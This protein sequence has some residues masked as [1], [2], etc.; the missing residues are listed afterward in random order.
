MINRKE[1]N[2]NLGVSPA[3]KKGQ[4]SG[5]PFQVRPH[6]NPRASG[7]PLLSLTQKKAAGGNGKYGWQGL[8]KSLPAIFS[9]PAKYFIS[10]TGSMALLFYWGFV[11]PLTRKSGLRLA[12]STHKA[13][14]QGPARPAAPP[15]PPA[16]ST[17][18]R[19][20]AHRPTRCIGVPTHLLTHLPM[21]RQWPTPGF[22]RRHL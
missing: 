10:P 4:G 8:K 20:H 11:P 2:N 22:P 1:Q 9:T 21:R 14:T 3:P 6:S 7:F 16:S 5:Y 17:A 19:G 12:P 18:L 13:N 15:R